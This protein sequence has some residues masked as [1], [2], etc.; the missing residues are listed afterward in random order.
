[1]PLLKYYYLL[2]LLVLLF[3]IKFTALNAQTTLYLWPENGASLPVEKRTDNIGHVRID[4]VGRPFLRVYEPNDG[5]EARGVVLICPGGGYGYLSITKEGDEVAEWLS[6]SGFLAV[7]LGSRLPHEAPTEDGWPVS[8]RDGLR[9]IELLREMMNEKDITQDKLIVMGFS[10]GGHLAA[11][12]V[13]ASRP[14]QRPSALILVYPVISMD[15]G[16][17]H[18]GSR[19]RLIGE[20]PSEHMI[21]RFSLEKGVKEHFPPTFLVHSTDDTA[22]PIENSLVYFEALRRVGVPAA[23]Y[24]PESGGHG[25]GLRPDLGWTES[26]LAWLNRQGF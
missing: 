11:S 13:Q 20:D 16:I 17:T 10:A 23:L 9:G 7:V 22:V 15:I 21:A 3:L 1:M 5:V 2:R 18:A 6:G 14:Q 19:R 25:F 4:R 24:A 26:A 8:Q 12:L